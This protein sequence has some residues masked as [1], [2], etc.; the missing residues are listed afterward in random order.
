LWD[1]DTDSDPAF[2]VNPDLDPIRIQSPIQSFDEKIEGEK[3]TAEKCFYLFFIKTY[4]LLI[5]RPP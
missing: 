2:Q 4:N 3:K 1:P 5:P